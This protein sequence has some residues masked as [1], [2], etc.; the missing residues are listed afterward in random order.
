[1]PEIIAQ[2]SFAQERIW[3][4][5]HLDPTDTSYQF[6]AALTFDGPLDVEALQ[7]ALDAI[8]ARHEAF[9]MTFGETA[10]APVARVASETKA[11]FT[12]VDTAAEGITI[13]DAIGAA[14][15]RRFDIAQLPLARWTL[16]RESPLRHVL[17]H[18]EHHLIHDGWSFN[19]FLGE[20]SRRYRAFASGAEQERDFAPSF[21]SYVA[22]QRENATSPA[23]QKQLAYWQ[24]TLAAAPPIVSLPLDR[25][26]PRVL[27][28]AG[29]V[30]IRVIPPRV[31]RSLERVAHVH[32]ATPFMTMFAAFLA[33]LH[34]YSRETDLCVGTGVAARDT[35]ETETLIG[36]LVTALVLRTDLSDDPTFAVL[37][38]RVR[39]VTLDAYANAGAPLSQI[40]ETLAP[41]R[42]PGHNPLFNIMFSFHDSP[43]PELD[44]GAVRAALDLTMDN[45]SAKLDLNI[46]VI[47]RPDG[48][49]LKWEY[50][51]DLFDRE[52]IASMADHFETLLIGAL[53]EPERRISRIGMMN[54]AEHRSILESF[55]ENRSSYPR[56]E[57]VTERFASIVRRSPEAIALVSNDGNLTY[58]ELDR[59]ATTLA[60]IM[61]ARGIAPGAHVGIMIHR[62]VEA[63]I[64]LLAVLKTG[65]A[66]IPL[67]FRYPAERIT[68]ITNDAEIALFL[69]HRGLGDVCPPD[70]PLLDLS[71]TPLDG[72]TTTASSVSSAGRQRTAES[73]AYVMYTSGSTG[74]PKGARVP[75]RAIM[76]L[77]T[78]G[79]PLE[80]APG[81]VSFQYAS[82]AF[83]GS[84]LEIWSALLNGATLAI[85]APGIL[86][87]AELG[88]A[89]ARFGATSAFLTTPLFHQIVDDRLDALGRLRR[90]A[91]GGDVLS[92]AH[93]FRCIA[94][95][96][97]LRLINGYGPTENTTFTTIH[98]VSDADARRRSIP[99]GRPVPNTSVY[100]LEPS[101]LPAPIGVP[102]EIVTGGDGVA[103]GYLN[104]PELTAE[105]FVDDTF[106]ENDGGLLYRT[107]DIGRWLPDGTIAYLG[108]D[109]GQRKIRGFR[110]ETG[111]VESVIRTHPAVT[112]VSVSVRDDGDDRTLIAHVSV[113]DPAT[114]AAT[115][116]T[117]YLRER[118][119]DYEIPARIIVSDV[120]PAS[121]GGKVDRAHLRTGFD[122][123]T[124]AA[125]ASVV[126]DAFRD[127]VEERLAGIWREVLR[128]ERL[129]RDQDF[130]AL[131]GHSLAMMRLAAR[132]RSSFDVELSLRILFER[133]TIA[134]MAKVLRETPLVGPKPKIDVRAL[135]DDE[136]DALLEGAHP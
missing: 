18:V 21:L 31:A 119:P 83:D 129:G 6:Q 71:V 27:T 123:A 57:P 54:N 98:E 1:M 95:H 111:A 91:V 53:D 112:G 30:L 47:P 126:D 63:V 39:T 104:R 3:F 12:I 124:D 107:G 58:A 8:V 125:A 85:P 19:R 56:D 59:R 29:D 78:S 62:S 116:L 122:P 13:Q 108:R 64:A 88:D 128:I 15:T 25:R 114:T 121:A 17:V 77:V 130:F 69:T 103:L 23:V 131:G 42:D 93:A 99:I 48:M 55:A 133:R 118:I 10:G 14:I 52:T 134:E 105:R 79:G 22:R 66:F 16:V 32:E 20:L 4:L 24:R 40:V 26:R 110:V 113:K 120:L 70:V 46:I 67:D 86:S 127:T 75:D 28:H 49:T 94:A 74:D 90:L 11:A 60:E 81:D 44:F 72:P 73:V 35:P 76:R 5:H 61:R 87:L 115:D 97:S 84:T 92:P 2:P 101:G 102:G 38:E 96:P 68:R 65:A 37:V 132:I 135:T 89:L 100:I 136:L 51:R 82:Y 109:D 117:A 34:R 43:E 45:G 9:R 106:G 7:Q 36:M 50:N 41:V 33:L 80:L